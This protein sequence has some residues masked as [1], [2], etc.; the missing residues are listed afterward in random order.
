MA[1]VAEQ[2]HVAI[3]P[4]PQ[5]IAVHDC[6]FMDVGACGQHL[7]DLTVEAGERLAQFPD[8]ALRRPRLDA[9]I[10]LRLAGDEVDLAAVGL[11][12]IDDDVAVLAPPFGAIVDLVAAQ[13]RGG[14]GGRRSAR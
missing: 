6:P 13:Q 12:V 2:R 7:F 10:R 11:D 1:G 3:R 14:I 5:R 8:V 4:S 9:E